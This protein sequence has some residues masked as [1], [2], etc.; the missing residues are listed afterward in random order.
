MG[1]IMSDE[2]IALLILITLSIIFGT[3]GVVYIIKS[4]KKKNRCS[5]EVVAEV[6][7]I[8]T[9]KSN[10]ITYTPIYSY[11]YNGKE[12]R[13]RSSISSSNIN[14]GIGDKV[15][16]KINPNKPKET[17]TKVDTTFMYMFGGLFTLGGAGCL[18][19]CILVSGLIPIPSIP[20]NE[21]TDH[22]MGIIIPVVMTCSM[23]AI[24][25]SLIMQDIKKRKRCSIEVRA[26]VADIV[27][28]R[29][30]H[31]GHLEITY[32]TLYRYEYKGHVYNGS[33]GSYSSRNKDRIGEKKYI[34]I[35]P[36]SPTEVMDSK[37]GITI[38]GVM[39]IGAGIISGLSLMGIMWS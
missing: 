19:A 5:K 23:V 9:D 27:E 13:S 21:N 22:I 38:F 34:M 33:T 2:V 16:L 15:K 12:Y 30:R 24:G 28:S 26:E 37:S 6:I 32:G 4:I 36:D 1:C 14:V 17:Y 29:N 25:V 7:D 35:N 39:F 18:I 11:N 20:N 8:D 31:D 10:G 3:I